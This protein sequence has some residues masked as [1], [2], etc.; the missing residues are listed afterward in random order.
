MKRDISVGVASSLI[1]AL[2]L[3]IGNFM[4]MALTDSQIQRLAVSVVDNKANRDVLLRAMSD[5][6]QFAGNAGPPGE[7]GQPGPDGP[8]WRPAVSFPRA[9]LSTNTPKTVAIG[10]HD[11]YA[12]NIAGENQ[13]NQKC[14]CK[15]SQASGNN[16]ELSVDLDARVTGSTC[17]CGAVCID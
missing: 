1:T 15:V 8:R 16:W 17:S 11:F 7:Q 13:H 6:G 12:L 10:T 4:S 3:W 14:V 5:S 2:V 9:I